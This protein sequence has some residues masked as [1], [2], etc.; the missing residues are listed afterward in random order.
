MGHEKSNFVTIDGSVD[1]NVSTICCSCRSFFEKER[2]WFSSNGDGTSSHCCLSIFVY[3]GKT[4]SRII[5]IVTNLLVK[6]RMGGLMCLKCRNEPTIIR[7]LRAT[8]TIALHL[9]LRMPYMTFFSLVKM[10]RHCS[11]N[12]LIGKMLVNHIKVELFNSEL[13]F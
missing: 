11:R 4:G 6:G 2:E 12:K 7:P 13:N 5:E 10:C 8:P 3:F 9:C 1:V